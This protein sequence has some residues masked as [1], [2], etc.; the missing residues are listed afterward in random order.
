[1]RKTSG[2]IIALAVVVGA[3]T[4]LVWSFVL[5]TVT[6]TANR[7]DDVDLAI[8]SAAVSRAATSQAVVFAV[9]VAS[10]TAT[11]EALDAAI[12]EAAANL[13]VY[14][15]LVAA[16]SA[17]GV[18][19]D[20]CRLD[21]LGTRGRA[22]LDL[23]N[24]VDVDAAR[25]M[26][27][28][29]FETGYRAALDELGSARTKLA[30]N[31]DSVNRWS[32]SIGYGVRLAVTL[33]IPSLAIFLFWWAA[34]Q[35]VL[36]HRR[37]ADERLA[38]EVQRGREKDALLAAVSQR[39]RAPLTSIHG[40]SDVLAQKKHIKGLDRELV[41][42]ISAESADMHRA[43]EDILT[44]SQLQAGTLAAAADI[45]SLADA[46]DDAVKPMWASGIDIKV[47][48]PEVWVVTDREKVR[49]ILRNLLSNA[50]GH[51]A[52]PIFVEGSEA[53][54]VVQCAVI[55]HGAGLPPGHWAD[56]SDP[57]GI[58]GGFK[59]A[60]GIG[61]EVAYSLAGLIGARLE[62][63]RV[64]DQT[65]FVMSFAED[66]DGAAG[67][68]RGRRSI[69]KRIPRPMRRQPPQEVGLV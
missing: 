15:Q 61:L 57:H 41:A 24:A 53:E 65:R 11:G 64:D 12:A 3:A 42:L 60:S 18:C 1:M 2:I 4:S 9:S 62:H 27:Q 5:P 7:L 10:G 39:F 13:D 25:A 63:F 17:S 14:D 58:E 19:V 69:I 23:I 8:G 22:V 20:A 29:D 48:C 68:E 40:L 52:A 32:D 28:N 51:G 67:T 50:V 30:S 16:L 47:E 44:A 34:R 54:G 43:V 46:I 45:I 56:S 33:V 6:Q 55:D 21:T 59:A 31:L 37:R 66:G 36:I 26:V 35:R 49:H 38:A